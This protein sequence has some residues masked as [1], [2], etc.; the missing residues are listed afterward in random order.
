MNIPSLY[1]ETQKGLFF[2]NRVFWKWIF[3]AILHSVFLFYLPMKAFKYGIVWENGFGG[4]Y[5]TLGNTVYSCVV[6]T[7]C[8]KAGMETNAWNWIIHL[9]I[10]GS[11]VSWFVYLLLTSFFWPTLPFFPDMAGMIIMLLKTPLFW[12]CM[13]LVPFCTLIPD[14]IFQ[15]IMITVY[16]GATDKVRLQE[17]GKVP[18]IDRMY[19][20]KHT[21]RSKNSNEEIELGNR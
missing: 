4:D 12:L 2:N 5:L 20:P 7:V 8:L 15:S 19:K 21:H 11:I 1:R 6:I 18:V 17:H 13:L 3:N 9:S 10:W 14:I 16:P